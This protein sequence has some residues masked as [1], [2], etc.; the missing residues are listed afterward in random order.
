L[1]QVFAF[2]KFEREENEAEM[3]KYTQNVYGNQEVDGGDYAANY[4]ERNEF[5][6]S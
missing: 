3:R 6:G 4:E 5:Q 1:H 2:E